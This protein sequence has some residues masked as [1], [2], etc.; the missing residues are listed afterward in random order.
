M[1]AIARRLFA[2]IR[3]NADYG[4]HQY[5]I[6]L[7]KLQSYIDGA[8][9][10][11]MI[12]IGGTSGSGKTSFTLFSYVYNPIMDCIRNNRKDLTI[13]IFCLEMTPE[14]TMS[15]LLSFYL[16]EKYGIEMGMRDLFSF[17]EKL[18][19]DKRKIVEE[20]EM[21][22]EKFEEYIRFVEGTV[23]SNTINDYVVKYYEKKGVF[24]GTKFIHNNPDH[25]TIGI[26]DHIGEVSVQSGK[27]KKVEIDDVADVCKKSRNI[28]GM[29][30]VILQQI[31]RGASAVGRRDRYKGLEMDDF[32]DSGNV[33]EKS[34][35]V[36]GIYYPFRMKDF[37]AG[38][39]N[40][41]ELKQIL[42]V[43]QVL[44]G[45]YGVADISIATAFYGC[46]GIFH[47]LPRSQDIVDYNR[48]KTPAWTKEQ[49]EIKNQLLDEI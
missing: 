36:I 34:D 32:K 48:Y 17:S 6:G 39:Y 49:N 30:W 28:F 22:M 24:N 4:V 47:E 15:K 37:E 25:I 35:I 11:V 1:G 14:L 46:S 16:W 3:T 44:K 23:N 9:K 21:M 27:T 31:N 5:S 19:G 10:S 2:E 26:I 43:I 29:S 7:P 33:N 42:K 45:R 13:I 20:S 41:R 12:N 38:G 18:T 40:V 8:R